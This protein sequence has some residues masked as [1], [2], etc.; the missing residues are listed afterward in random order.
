MARYIQVAVYPLKQPLT[1]RSELDQ[2]VAVGTMVQVP[3]GNSKR[4]GFVVGAADAPPA[5]VLTKIKPIAAIVEATPTFSPETLRIFEWCAHYYGHPVSEVIHT[6]LPA[7]VKPK[8]T[9]VISIGEMPLPAKS[10]KVEQLVYAMITSQEGPIAHGALNHLAGRT[11]ALATLKKMAEKGSILLAES[12][13]IAH[14]QILPSPEWA[15][16]SVQLSD[17]QQ[18]CVALIDASRGETPPRPLLL[19][20]ITGSGKTEVYIDVVL[21]TLAH[22][23]SCLILVPEI[24][25]TPQL[26]DRF[27]AR[28]NQPIAVLHSGLSERVRWENWMSIAQGAC[29]VAI[30]ARSA[31]FAPM[32][33]LGLIIVDE[34][35]EGSF[36]QQEGIRYHARDLAIVR[37]RNAGCPIILGSATPSLESVYN[38]ARKKYQ[39]FTLA[40]RHTG[41]ALSPVTLVD[42]NRTK[43]S[44][45]AS[46]SVSCTL[47]ASLQDALLRGEQAFVLYNRRGFASYLQCS[48]CGA[49]ISCPNCSVT[50]VMHKGKD[51]LLCHFC[52]YTRLP[53]Q[54]CASCKAEPNDDGS[55]IVHRGSGTERVSEELAAL[56]PGI[57]MQRLDRDTVTTETEYRAILDNLRT[58]ETQLLV[59]TQMIAKGHDL[60]L[61]TAVGIIDADV[62]L[63]VPDFRASER[64]FQLLTQVAGR[65]GRA[66]KKGTVVL[67][68]RLPEHPSIALA[69]QGNFM[70]FATQELK[71]RAEGRYPPFAYLLRIVASSTESQE[72]GKALKELTDFIR[73]L[74]LNEKLPAMLLGPAPA[75][76]EKIKTRWRVHTLV[77]AMH[78][79]TI[80]RIIEVVQEIT[81]KNS[82]VRITW[83]VDPVDML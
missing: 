38:A 83:D 82:S 10:G 48:A 55:P 14:P 71:V 62:G 41:Q 65:A 43:P 4:T 58:G 67:Q 33:D 57:S 15:K 8:K 47:L 81:G 26:V 25:L 20:G 79:P 9:T 68:T 28:I 50:L 12:H 40:S 19:H 22:N 5:E 32:K 72:A 49:S 24:A 53:P 36:K 69:T 44:E 75:P 54:S 80:H 77:K 59:G 7:F 46:P 1:Y 42:L 13:E 30:G 27:R 34:E 2:D 61:V 66:D 51:T 45:M 74:I 60:P 37:A 23:R 56:L 35:H 52:G 63:H 6:A 78:R 73:T 3:V 76:I 17:Q 11:V 29:S 64:V 18:A 31:V 70:E 39:S 21:E 16:R